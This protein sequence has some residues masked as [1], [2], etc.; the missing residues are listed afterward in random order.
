MVHILP[1]WNW[2]DRLGQITPVHVFT[3]GDAA[4]LFINGNSQGLKQKKPGEYRIRWDQ[5]RYEP[6]RLKVVAYKNGQVWAEQQ[7]A[8][9]G[10]PC[11]LAL[12]T[13]Q[14]EPAALLFVTIRVEDCAG[15]L[16]PTAKLPFQIDLA[17]ATDAEL[18]AT[19]NGDP[20]DFTPFSA[21]ARKTFNG[22]GLAIVRPAAGSAVTHITVSSPGLIPAQL[23]WPASPAKEQHPD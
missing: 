2:P 3:S 8:T 6:G 4:E 13:E 1:H 16:V 5:V 19:D 15:Q 21:S 20:T 17:G 23:T 10:A 7:I 14:P 9:T 11:R 12:Q 22:L 18:L